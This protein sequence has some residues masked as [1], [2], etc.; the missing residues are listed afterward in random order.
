MRQEKTALAAWSQKVSLS[1]GFSFPAL[2][3]SFPSQEPISGNQ[4]MIVI[5]IIWPPFAHE[6]KRKRE[7]KK[8]KHQNIAHIIIMPWN[9][10]TPNSDSTI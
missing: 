1:T 8:K 7:Q 5:G 6:K 4:E 3:T 2:S 10:T 9:V